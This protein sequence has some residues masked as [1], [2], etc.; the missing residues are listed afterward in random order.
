MDFCSTRPQ[1]H[2]AFT[3]GAPVF[4][5]SGK[6][7]SGGRKLSQTAAGAAKQSGSAKS[8]VVD[9]TDSRLEGDLLAPPTAN[10]EYHI[11]GPK[12]TVGAP[13][14]DGSGRLISAGRKLSQAA[15]VEAKRSG[16]IAAP[17]KATPVK[18]APAAT[19]KTSAPIVVDMTGTALEGFMLSGRSP[20][21]LAKIEG[22]PGTAAAASTATFDGF[23]RPIPTSGR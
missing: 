15:A 9:M 11:E 18:P 5:G 8:T 1:L 2:L 20:S 4:D 21:A 3:Q 16:T 13:I 23:G 22:P 10:G 19:T 6:L 17:V 7:I 14:F 12:S